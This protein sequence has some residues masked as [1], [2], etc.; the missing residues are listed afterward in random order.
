MT[1]TTMRAPDVQ[2]PPSEPRLTPK[3]L[4][5]RWPGVTPQ[6][7]AQWRYL[8]FGPSYIK[9]GKFVFYPLSAVLAYE[10]ENTVECAGA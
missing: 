4:A 8:R 9:A 3:Q 10:R 6:R 2:L 5:E 1:R 7:L